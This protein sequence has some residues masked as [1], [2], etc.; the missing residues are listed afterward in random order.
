[1]K[2]RGNKDPDRK[3][4]RIYMLTCLGILIVMV[5]VIFVLLLGHLDAYN[6]SAEDKGG[7]QS[8]AER[9]KRL[10]L[11]N[12][13]IPEEE[14]EPLPQEGP[15]SEIQFTPVLILQSND[16]I[17]VVIRTSNFANQYHNCIKLSCNQDFT[18]QEGKWISES[19][20]ECASLDSQ[21]GTD[22]YWKPEEEK[23]YKAEKCIEFRAEDLAPGTCIRLFGGDFQVENIKRAYGTPIYGDVLEI[24]STDSGLVLIN[25]L[26]LETYLCGCVPSEM[27]SSYPLEALKAQAIS[28]RTYACR[29]L[30]NPGY[31]QFGAHLDDSTNYQVFNNIRPQES[32]NKAVQETA[33]QILFTSTGQLTESYYYSTSCGLGANGDIW[34]NDNYPE[35]L[36]AKF[37]N[38]KAMDAYL[39]NSTSPLLEDYEKDYS[40]GDVFAAYISEIQPDDFEDRESWYRWKYEVEELDIEQLWEQLLSCSK[41]GKWNV[42]TLEKGKFVNTAPKEFK[43]VQRMVISERGMGGNVQVMLLYTDSGIYQVQGGQNIRTLLLNNSQQFRIVDGSY[44]TLANMLPS[45]FFILNTG[46]E[47]GNVVGYTIVGG[48]LGHGVGMSQNAAKNMAYA[49]YTADEIL[50]YFYNDCLVYAGG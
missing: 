39:E 44:A 3:I 33:G 43:S 15:A 35:Y 2:K 12:F 11:L 31:P 34:G 23:K 20:N 32:T 27:P 24:R 38:E 19:G 6:N 48:G 26:P 42:L 22:V 49:G 30:L 41:K 25:E 45:S 47:D 40:Q 8:I 1:M 37:L 50:R 29:F 7:K 18:V 46:K 28:A 21:E 16:L 17:R 36:D 4:K 10:F 14:K 9:T 13:D 5:E